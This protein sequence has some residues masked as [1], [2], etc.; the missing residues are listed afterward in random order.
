MEDVEDVIRG[1]ILFLFRFFVILIILSTILFL[2][3]NWK[4]ICK[5]IKRRIRYN[6]IVDAAEM[7]NL[8]LDKSDMVIRHSTDD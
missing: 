7:A 8:D 5:I 2:F 1:D 4:K 3:V 6:H